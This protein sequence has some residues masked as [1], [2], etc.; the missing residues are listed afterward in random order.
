MLQLSQ[1]ESNV[2]Y[3]SKGW[4]DG[5]KQ[6]EHFWPQLKILCDEY[7]GMDGDIGDI[8][9]VIR[10][11][12]RKII[13]LMPNKDFLLDDYENETL[14][15]KIRFYWGA[16]NQKNR[17]WNC[18]DSFNGEQMLQARVAKMISQIS[19]TEVKYY[20]SLTPEDIGGLKVE[21]RE[22]LEQMIKTRQNNKD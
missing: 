12:W 9:S 6:A 18:N 20:E 3:W 7:Y 1:H 5:G 22:K 14:P 19:N 8:Y 15:H 21:K 17:D 11:F 13:D 16:P 10:T 2:L 4:Y